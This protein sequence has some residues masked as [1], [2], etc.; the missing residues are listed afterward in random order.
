[1]EDTRVTIRLLPEKAHVYQD[2]KDVVTKRLHSDV[3]YVTTMLMES[4]V[5]AVQETPN[6]DNPLE[7]NFV[8]QNIQ[9]NMGCD[10]NYY[11]K[12]ARRTPSDL[13]EITTDT[14]N[15]LPNVLN[16]FPELNAKAREFWFREFQLQGLIPKQTRDPYVSTAK[17]KQSRWKK[18]IYYCKTIMR[19]LRMK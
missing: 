1:M 4:F 6:P 2:F 11:T 7:M 15:V 14:H 19:H 10:F 16:Q 5:N 8:K 18:L 9:I 12:K 3:C 17:P 13:S